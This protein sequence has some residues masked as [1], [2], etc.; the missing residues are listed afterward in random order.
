MGLLGV[1]IFCVLVAGFGS[2]LLFLWCSCVWVVCVDLFLESVGF[3]GSFVSYA[4]VAYLLFEPGSLGISVK[5]SLG[6]FG[7][8]G[9][10]GHGFAAKIS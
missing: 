7:V 3:R 9:K 4:V 8:F 6:V 5:G 2:C 1:V 10:D